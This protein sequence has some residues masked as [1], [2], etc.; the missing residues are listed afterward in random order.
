M[1]PSEQELP[2]EVAD[3][4]GVKIDNCNIFKSTHTQSLHQLAPEATSAHNEHFGALNFFC[5]IFCVNNF[6]FSCIL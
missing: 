2:V 5:N 1:L 4:D 6:N 3:I